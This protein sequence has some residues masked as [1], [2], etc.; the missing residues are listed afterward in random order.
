MLSENHFR[1]LPV[2]GSYQH[3]GYT[4]KDLMVSFINSIPEITEN[5]EIKIE[6]EYLDKDKMK[7]K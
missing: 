5:I 1:F 2:Y 3:Y 7:S 4:N 6:M